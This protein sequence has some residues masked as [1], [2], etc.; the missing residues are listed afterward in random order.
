VVV[1]DLA[2]GPVAH[3]APDVS[4]WPSSTGSI[5]RRPRSPIRG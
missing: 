3:D 1:D 4:T 2:A 5:P